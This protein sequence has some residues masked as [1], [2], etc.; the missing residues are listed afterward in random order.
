MKIL[1]IGDSY[2]YGSELSDLNKAWPVLVANQL[3]CEVDNKGKPAGSNYRIVRKLLESNIT[4]YDIVLI[5]WS[6]FDR[7]EF[8]DDCGV[9]DLWPGGKRTDYKKEFPVRSTLIDYITRNHNDDYLYQQY[10]MQIILT[11]TYLKHHNKKYVMMD[12]FINAEQPMRFAEQNQHLFNE[13]DSTKF[14]GW[15]DTT[16][17]DWAKDTPH[18]PGLHFLDEGHQIVANRVYNCLQE[19]L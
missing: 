10:L 1:A 2:T 5:G 14:I 17:M 19:Q 11:Q 15:P 4:N 3:G 12:A 18:G 13:V 8:C 16:M 7:I 6:G 9:W